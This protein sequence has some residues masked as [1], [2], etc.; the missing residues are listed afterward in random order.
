M[1]TQFAVSWTDESGVPREFIIYAKN[2]EDAKYQV[3]APKDATVKLSHL[4]KKD[5][6]TILMKR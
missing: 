2:E 1:L 5:L 3:S 4:T 6:M